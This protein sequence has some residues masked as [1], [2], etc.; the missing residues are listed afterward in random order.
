MNPAKYMI[1][2]LLPFMASSCELKTVRTESGTV[3]SEAIISDL[4][5]SKPVYIENKTIEG[6]LDFTGLPSVREGENMQR[7]MITGSVTFVKC[8]FA[9][10]LTGFSSKS[11]MTTVCSFYQN[12]TFSDCELEDEVSMQEI[13]VK[14]KAKFTNDIFHR[15]VSF[16]GARFS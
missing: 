9:G 5:D 6:D 8:R 14:G 1:L 4:R 3:K 12:L 15:S 2:L 10:K 16:E 13:T 11:S 7:V